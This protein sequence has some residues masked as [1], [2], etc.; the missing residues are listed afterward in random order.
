MKLARHLL[1]K[2]KATRRPVLWH[3]D[4]HTDNIFVDPE[5]PAKITRCGRWQAV[6]IAPLFLQVHRPALLDL[7]GPIPER[8]NPS[9][10]AENF[11]E[12]SPEEKLRAKKLHAAQAMY[13]LKYEIELLQQCK[14]AS[15]VAGAGNTGEPD[16]WSG[17]ISFY[18]W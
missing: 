3:S 15:R 9:Q 6:H 18:E 4:L 17:G 1:P 2:N 7:D 14:D 10:L 12:L 16:H 5:E 13:V 8:L 11:D